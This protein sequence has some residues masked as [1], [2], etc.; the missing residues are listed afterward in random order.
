LNN[1]PII[2]NH[3]QALLDMCERRLVKYAIG[4]LKYSHDIQLQY[5]FIMENSNELTREVLRDIFQIMG[6]SIE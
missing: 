2:I 6:E 3:R 4:D 5:Q 1:D